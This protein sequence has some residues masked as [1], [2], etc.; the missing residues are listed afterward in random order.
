MIQLSDLG[1][2]MLRRLCSS[3]GTLLLLPTPCLLPG[4]S[5]SFLSLFLS[6]S[7]VQSGPFF[8]D[9]LPVLGLRL[10]LH[11]LTL[12][13][14]H[15]VE[16]NVLPGCRRTAYALLFLTPLLTRGGRPARDGEIG[17]RTLPHLDIII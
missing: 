1:Q 2:Q 14:I 9:A 10:S 3:I 7:L 16:A 11:P 8:L 17:E 4:L 13:L 12:A 6:I 15:C 5:L